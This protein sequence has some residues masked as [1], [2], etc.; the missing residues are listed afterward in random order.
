MASEEIAVVSVVQR[1]QSKRGAA[2]VGK[3]GLGRPQ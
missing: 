2:K 1:W 3:T